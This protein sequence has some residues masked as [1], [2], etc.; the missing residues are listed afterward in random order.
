M[1]SC[2]RGGH[3]RLFL[4]LPCILFLRGALHLA[5]SIAGSARGPC[6]CAEAL[7][8]VRARHGHP[9]AAPGLWEAAEVV[10]VGEAGC[11]V[12]LVASGRR[13]R[14]LHANVATSRFAEGHDA[15]A[16]GDDEGTAAPR[17]SD[18]SEEE[19]ASEA[20]ACDP[21]S[22]WAAGEDSNGEGSEDED[23]E[24][25]DRGVGAFGRTAMALAPTAAAA[26]QVQPYTSMDAKP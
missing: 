21:M 10:D 6:C 13:A 9:S 26:V 4:A 24:G 12:V 19:G 14:I 11:D 1:W 5:G 22:S 25:V 7:S 2:C 23:D 8:L 15:D 17:V 16:N 18:A 20:L 3:L